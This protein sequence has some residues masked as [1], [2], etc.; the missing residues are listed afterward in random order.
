MILRAAYVWGDYDVGLLARALCLAKV[1]QKLGK[2]MKWLWTKDLRLQGVNVNS[3]CDAAWKAAAWCASPTST[4]LAGIDR[5]F[6]IAE[7]DTSQGTLANIIAKVFNISTG[8]Q[9]MLISSFARLNL[10][11]V[12]DDV[13]EEVLQPWADALKDKG[14]AGSG[15][16]S[17]FIEK[18]LLRECH[19]CLNA[20]KAERVL[21]WR[22][23][24]GF[25]EEEVRGVVESYRRMGWW[26]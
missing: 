10:E 23:R 24:A 15:P 9:G 19:L 20:E 12:T 18:E 1:Y 11:S 5:I 22:R 13:N 8:F 2:E 3:L 14:M 7:G 21:G 6:N 26:P 25:D 4:S 17:P 16:L